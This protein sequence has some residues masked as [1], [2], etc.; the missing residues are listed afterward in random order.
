MC[1]IQHAASHP[2]RHFLDQTLHALHSRL[3]FFEFAQHSG[4]SLR[5]QDLGG[6]PGD[7]HLVSDLVDR[8]SDQSQGHCLHDHELDVLEGDA[9]GLL[10]GFKR[11]DSVAFGQVEG[12]FEEGHQS[13][14]LLQFLPIVL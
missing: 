10:Q 11:D 3:P 4:D 5:L 2:H 1:I 13:D 12:Q 7:G 9:A 8:S 14:L 6:D